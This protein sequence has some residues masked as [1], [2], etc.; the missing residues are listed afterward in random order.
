MYF[1]LANRKY[2]LYQIFDSLRLYYLKF[3]NNFLLQ[4]NI[5]KFQNEI[6]DCQNFLK[7]IFIS[8][9]G[10]DYLIDPKYFNLRNLS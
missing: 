9:L 6:N 10:I 8:R 7:N 1:I 2:F 4:I 3:F 5:L